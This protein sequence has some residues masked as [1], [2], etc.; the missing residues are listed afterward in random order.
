MEED[1]EYLA[2]LYAIERAAEGVQT[3]ENFIEFL[4][5]LQAEIEEDDE[6]IERT[7]NEFFR[8]LET[9]L[10][11]SLKSPERDNYIEEVPDNPDWNWLAH[12]F[13]VGAFQN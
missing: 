6:L 2:E 7:Q 13:L 1:E 11:V 3:A 8:V 4:R 9:K 12:L 5:K 10:N